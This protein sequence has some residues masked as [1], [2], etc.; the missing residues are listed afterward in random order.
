[1]RRTGARV[2][3]LDARD[4][5]P[6]GHRLDQPRKRERQLSRLKGFKPSRIPF[7]HEFEV[8]EAYDGISTPTGVLI[9]ADGLIESGLAVSRDA[10]RELLQ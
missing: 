10:I 4:G 5:K 3:T 1:M 6:A 2:D 7:Q 9:S 8:S